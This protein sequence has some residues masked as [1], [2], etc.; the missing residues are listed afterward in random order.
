MQAIMKFEVN[1]RA[2]TTKALARDIVIAARKQL[3]DLG[4]EQFNKQAQ[5]ALMSKSMLIYDASVTLELGNKPKEFKVLFSFK[6]IPPCDGAGFE[7]SLHELWLIDSPK[8]HDYS[9]MLEQSHITKDIEE[10]LSN[11]QEI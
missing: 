10:Q 2:T 9:I 7:Y 3:S 5:I 1:S 8:N 4:V 11:D 6:K